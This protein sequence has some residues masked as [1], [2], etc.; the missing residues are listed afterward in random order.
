LETAL[1]SL[2]R[3]L[4]VCDVVPAEPNNP[5][6]EL[7]DC[8][9]ELTAIREQVALLRINVEKGIKVAVGALHALEGREKDTARR[10]FEAQER[11]TTSPTEAWRTMR[12]LAAAL[13]ATENQIDARL[14]LQAAL[15]R[16]IDRVYLLVTKAGKNRCAAAQIHFHASPRTLLVHIFHHPPWAA[17]N[18]RRLP[19][20]WWAYVVRDQSSGA[21]FDLR[22][23]KDAA[24]MER[25][26]ASRI[27]ANIAPDVRRCREIDAFHALAGE[28]VVPTTSSITAALWNIN[29]KRATLRASVLAKEFASKDVRTQRNHLK[30]AEEACQALRVRIASSAKERILGSA[31]NSVDD[32]E[33]GGRMATG[34]TSEEMYIVDI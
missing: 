12:R 28:E 13:D 25:G 26:L 20:R 24:R 5:L 31:M 3:Q 17:R 22:N 15:R 10:F 34:E 29:D 6:Q 30:F 7:L 19:G 16:V 21:Q 33:I 4:D 11:V 27:R 32:S 8:A 1:V 18:G 14:R 9:G 23:P 2:L